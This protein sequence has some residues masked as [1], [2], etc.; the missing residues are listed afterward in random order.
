M[1]R[2]CRPLTMSEALK[3]GCAST[4][5]V[6]SP[7][8]LSIL[9]P[10]LLLPLL[11]SLLPQNDRSSETTTR[12]VR[13]RTISSLSHRPLPFLLHHRLRPPSPSTVKRPSLPLLP[14][15]ASSLLRRRRSQRRLRRGR[16]RGRMQ[17][18][19]RQSL[20][21]PQRRKKRLSRGRGKAGRNLR[22]RGR[23]RQRRVRRRWRSFSCR[24]LTFRSILRSWR[25]RS[26]CALLLFF[27]SLPSA[28]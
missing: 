27:L 21:T 7:V 8:L 5:A 24:L 25:R 17:K 9:D 18:R 4:A 13:T 26:R 22:R 6:S 16:A 11:P 28:S 12:A 15:S 20:M 10:F 1:N 2:S 14:A 3:P 23:E 19:R